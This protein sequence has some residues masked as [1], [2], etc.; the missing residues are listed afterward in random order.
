MSTE[1]KNKSD[2]YLRAY[3][4]TSHVLSLIRKHSAL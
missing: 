3:K 1:E 2:F 4:L